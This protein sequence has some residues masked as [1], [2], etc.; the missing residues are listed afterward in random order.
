MIK[1][2]TFNP[3]SYELKLIASSDEDKKIMMEWFKSSTEL[4]SFE[5][6]VT[7]FWD[8]MP[9]CNCAEPNLSNNKITICKT[10]KGKK[11]IS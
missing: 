9:D 7:K 2:F 11:L 10:C 8:R 1:T 5:E 6:Y 3:D 4:P